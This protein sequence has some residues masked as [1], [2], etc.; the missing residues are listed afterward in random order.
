MPPLRSARGQTF[1]SRENTRPD[2]LLAFWQRRGVTLIGATMQLP[3]YSP[4]AP[5]ATVRAGPATGRP[6]SPAAGRSNAHSRVRRLAPDPPFLPLGRGRFRAQ[7]R[8]PR[9]RIVVGDAD[10]AALSAAAERFAAGIE[11][12][13]VGPRRL[14]VA[15]SSVG[16]A[17][18]TARP[19]DARGESIAKFPSTERDGRID[20]VGREAA[21]PDLAS[22]A[23]LAAPDHRLI[24]LGRTR[25][26][27]LL[28]RRLDV[29]G[30]TGR[31][32][33]ISLRALCKEQEKLCHCLPHRGDTG[34]SHGLPRG[35]V[36]EA[37]VR[38]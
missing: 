28:V 2:F 11:S 18:P 15:G 12:D 17:R 10:F 36:R 9:V 32:H 29:A 24:P 30:A 31:R 4:A 5:A 16:G 37:S 22:V 26:R 8:E 21:G 23:D 7:M 13:A 38:E 3:R 27:A 19:S 25:R 14:C 6:C 33:M 35:R 34:R 20:V 1:R